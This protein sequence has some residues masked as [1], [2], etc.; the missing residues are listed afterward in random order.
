MA[1]FLTAALCAV[2]NIAR[3]CRIQACIVFFT[4][5]CGPVGWRLKQALHIPYVISL[6]GGDVPGLVPEL[7]VIHRAL[8][9]VRRIILNGA[10]AVVAN[11]E[12]LARLSSAADPVRVRVI[13]NGVDAS[14][15]RPCHRVVPTSQYRILFAGRLHAQKNLIL[16]LSALAALRSS[17]EV[18][19]TLDVV[20]DGPLRE[21]LQR[22]AQRLS[23]TGITWHGWLQ[24]S[25]LAELYRSADVFVNPSLYEG[26]PN[27]VLEA[28]ASGLPIVASRIGGNDALVKHG[29]T[30]LLF[31]L[32][33]DT[34][35]QAALSTL[36]RDR[37]LG[38]RMG[39][40]GRQLVVSDFSWAAAARAYVA[41]LPSTV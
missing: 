30:G 23:L 2:T 18:R 35:F 38:L 27:T 4:V 32:R 37:E 33:V 7:N 17:T 26:L 9:P 28:M 1:G 16:V 10:E 41:L 19:V 14:F 24:K 5:P 22:E 40:A 21:E 13:P 31:D 36:L 8:T 12:S 11:S 39:A 34:A 29:V 15:F 20:G 3:E 25:R 6:R